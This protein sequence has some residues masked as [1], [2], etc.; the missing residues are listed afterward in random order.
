[1][2]DPALK[3]AL[4]NFRAVRSRKPAGG[5]QQALAD[6]REA[7]ADALDALAVVLVFESDRQQARAAAAAIRS[8]R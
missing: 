4:R 3:D 7:M 8:G 1:V 2:L 6:W 5:G